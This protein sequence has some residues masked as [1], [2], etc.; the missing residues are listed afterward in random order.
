MKKIKIFS[1]FV[2]LAMLVVACHNDDDERESYYVQ[3]L[4]YMAD[5]NFLRSFV[6]EDCWV[7]MTEGI[8]SVEDKFYNVLCYRMG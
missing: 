1:L 2:C 8:Q 4:V 6:T 7:K 3:C 5:D